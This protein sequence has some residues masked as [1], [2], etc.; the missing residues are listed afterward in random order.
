MKR[1]EYVHLDLLPLKPLGG[2]SMITPEE[3]RLLKAFELE[4]PSEAACVAHVRERIA[5][6]GLM[7]CHKCQSRE[8]EYDSDRTIRC[9]D[10]KKVSWFTAGTF[11]NRIKKL[12]A[13]VGIM[14]FQEHNMPLSSSRA[15]ILL[16]IAQ[17]TAWSM[18][19]KIH[20]ALLPAL[21]L[22]VR[23][24]MAIAC[25]AFR[26][27]IRKR[28]RETPAREHPLA[29]M[30][31]FRRRPKDEKKTDQQSG[32]AAE[33]PRDERQ[34]QKEKNR[35]KDNKTSNKKQNANEKPEG[36]ANDSNPPLGAFAGSA[37]AKLPMEQ[38]QILEILVQESQPV[39]V[40]K[41]GVLTGLPLDTVLLQL[42]YLQLENLVKLASM[43]TYSVDHTNFAY[44]RARTASQESDWLESIEDAV[45]G[46]I[47][48]CHLTFHG[49]SRKYLQ[50][51]LSYFAW[52]QRNSQS[53]WDDLMT[54]LIKHPPIGH[55]TVLTYISPPAVLIALQQKS[56]A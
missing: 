51:Y 18:T 24:A 30:D 31:S 55:S 28:S 36:G 33:E 15:Q 26:D 54:L 35:K 29:E 49:S 40:D 39:H 50:L 27:A 47:E 34:Q 5:D 43:G 7:V 1:I 22:N 44:L 2:S 20:L 16:K 3:E 41:L 23:D 11:F 53:R 48:F 32:E 38:Q 4:F 52:A 21:Q 45:A 37:A 56:T 14:W 8:V 6:Q 9:L 46:F 13:F 42:T 12:K 10:C 25:E 17:S 19:K